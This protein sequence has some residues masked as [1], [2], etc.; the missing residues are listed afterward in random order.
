MKA[1]CPNNWKHEEFHVSAHVVQDWK[2]D[3]EGNWLE[4][5]D[6]CVEVTHKI[7]QDSIWTCST[8]GAEAKVKV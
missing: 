5:I 6:E 3:A 7:N 8:C 4:T 2:V 1:T